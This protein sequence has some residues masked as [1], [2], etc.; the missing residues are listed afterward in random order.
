MNKCENFMFCKPGKLEFLSNF[1]KSCIS[2]FIQFIIFR[3][4][5]ITKSHIFQELE[6]NFKKS[7][8]FQ[9]LELNYFILIS[10]HLVLSFGKI[11]ICCCCDFYNF[12][13]QFKFKVF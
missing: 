8:I 6:L 10:N 12:F 11:Y 9:E 5:S 1:E 13:F 4:F 3:G 2:H 7:H